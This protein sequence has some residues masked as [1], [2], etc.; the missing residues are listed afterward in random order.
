MK[1]EIFLDG[2]LLHTFTG[3][4]ATTLAFAKLLRI[5]PNSVNHALRYEG[6]KVVDTDEQGRQL[7][8]AP[9]PLNRNPYNSTQDE[10]K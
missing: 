5:Q 7:E 1:T 3:Q 4:D 8:W 9:Y 6:Y 2:V 10:N